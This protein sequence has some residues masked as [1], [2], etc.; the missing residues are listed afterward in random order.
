M[1]T[2]VELRTV[3]ANFA[4]GVTLLTTLKADGSVQAMTANAF[5]SIALDP[6]LV[7]VSIGNARN[8]Y[9]HVKQSGRYA[10]SVLR[11]D[12]IEIARHFAQEDDERTDNAPV[13]YSQSKAEMPVV[14]GCLAFLDC[15]VV[16]THPH[17][18]HTI[19]VAE[20]VETQISSGE[21]LIFTPAS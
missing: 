2:G 18:D 13:E 3:M 1:V 9:P 6:P 7:M 15:K 10:I 4:T 17:G 5:A 16:A 14:T 20:V 11:S 8:T 12:Q 21:P 19:F